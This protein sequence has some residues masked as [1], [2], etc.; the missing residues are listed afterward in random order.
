MKADPAVEDDRRRQDERDPLPAGEL[1]R[2]HHRE[3]RDGHRQD[4]RDDEPTRQNG[5]RL[6]AVRRAFAR[7]R[8]A[9]EARAVA[10]RLDGA[11]ELVDRTGGIAAHGRLLGGEVDRR[12]DALELVELLLDA[13][14]TR[15]A[16]HA[17]EIESK[18][19][20]PRPATLRYYADGSA[21]LRSNALM[22]SLV[23]ISWS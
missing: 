10:G 21:G 20:T 3:Q 11:D 5:E 14:C 7:V 16:G 8:R 12:L 6:V 9:R 1:Q 22:C 18:R 19:Q 23:K 4:E 2:R 17:L 15:R 13:R